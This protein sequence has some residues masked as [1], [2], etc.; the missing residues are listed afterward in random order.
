MVFLRKASAARSRYIKL[1][2]HACKCS[3]I[4]SILLPR[5]LVCLESQIFR[6]LFESISTAVVANGM[7]KLD[8]NNNQ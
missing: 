2:C 3:K 7:E 8:K 6:N 1:M 4:G 5:L